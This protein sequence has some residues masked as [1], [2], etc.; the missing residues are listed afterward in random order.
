VVQVETTAVEI[1]RLV[2]IQEAVE[3]VLLDIMAAPED[4]G[5]PA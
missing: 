3:A 1:M 5:P 4:L 2:L